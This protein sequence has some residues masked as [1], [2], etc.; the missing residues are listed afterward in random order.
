MSQA[1]LLPGSFILVCEYQRISSTSIAQWWRQV[2]PN[3]VEVTSIEPEKSIKIKEVRE[4]QS[5]LAIGLANRSH[6]LIILNPADKITLPAQQALLKLLEE[7]P[8]NTT[9]VLAVS[10]P[11]VL[12]P[13]IQSRCRLLHWRSLAE[14]NRHTKSSKEAIIKENNDVFLND[15]I[16][17]TNNFID[18]MISCSTNREMVLF[19]QQQSKTKDDVTKLITKF[20][21]DQNWLL[22]NQERPKLEHYHKLREK[23]IEV[24]AAL[25]NNVNPQLCLEKWLLPIE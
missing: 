10:S 23:G 13:T 1:T 14:I 4:L 7:P 17:I 11:Q 20:L 21:V 25:N 15:K 9:F 6:R 19:L 22:Q 18:Q 5:K 24:L 8:N 3:G 16:S 2:L 12:L